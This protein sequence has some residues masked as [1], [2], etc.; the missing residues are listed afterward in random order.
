M[1]PDKFFSPQH[2]EELRDFLIAQGVPLKLWGKGQAKYVK[3]LWQELQAGES[4]LTAVPLR[5]RVEMV[6]LIIRRGEKMLIEMEQQLADGRT[7]TRHIPPSEKLQRNEHFLDA[8]YRGLQEELHIPPDQAVMKLDTYRK[9]T[10]EQL[11]SSYP[12]LITEYHIHTIEV[13]VPGLPQH[14]FS[15]QEPPVSTD[16]ITKAHIWDW[17]FPPAQYQAV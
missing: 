9:K 4:R 11:S 12:G 17:R 13:D 16:T 10:V 6:S 2:E 14:R 5:R 8:A 15:T 7:R 3:S 1:S